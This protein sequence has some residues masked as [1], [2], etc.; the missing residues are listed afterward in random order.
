M[1]ETKFSPN[2]TIKLGT[3][4]KLHQL[5]AKNIPALLKFYKSGYMYSYKYNTKS[6]NLKV[7]QFCS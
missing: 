1:C 6:F 2:R 3:L 5:N 7:F 4:N